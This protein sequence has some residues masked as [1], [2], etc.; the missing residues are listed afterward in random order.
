MPTVWIA[1]LALTA[2]ASQEPASS[3]DAPAADSTPIVS[4][5]GQSPS[6][7]DRAEETG[8][9]GASL[10]KRTGR[11]LL[12]A[13][14]ETLARLARPK[15]DQLE[16]SIEEILFVHQE[17]REDDAMAGSQ[18][19]YYTAKVESR[20]NQLSI[21]LKKRIAR[22][23][24]LAKRRPPQQIRI[25]E[26]PGEQLAQRVGGAAPPVQ[27]LVGGGGAPARGR[28][29]NDDYG[30]QLVDL[31]QKTIAPSTWDVNG[32]LGTIYYWRPGRALVV[33]QTGEVHEQMGDALGQ[34]RRAGP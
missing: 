23:K 8:K 31:I 5:D 2:A 9:P 34:L 26:N 1:V 20:L 27:P 32:G 24:R 17:L 4:A 13:V 25:P 11:E 6:A 22:N 10:R 19:E 14:R 30:Q 21:Q 12:A 28:Q 7:A 3:A 16:A 15:D 29:P 18:R 33:R